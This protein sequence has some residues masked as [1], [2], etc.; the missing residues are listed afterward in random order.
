MDIE[1][2]LLRCDRLLRKV[3]EDIEDYKEII[4]ALNILLVVVSTHT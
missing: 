1:G 3:Q 2:V 4:K